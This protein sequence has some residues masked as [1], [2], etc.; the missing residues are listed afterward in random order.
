MYQFNVLKHSL[1]G[2]THHHEV[3][4]ESRA[5]WLHGTRVWVVIYLT[6]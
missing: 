1:Q 6:S 3:G 5:V 2:P 4:T